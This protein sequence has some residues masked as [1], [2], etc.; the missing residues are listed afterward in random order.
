MKVYKTQDIRNVV[1]LGH[2]GCGKA[3]LAG[4]RAPASG[5]AHRRGRVGPG[6]H[7]DPRRGQLH[8]AG[9]QGLVPQHTGSGDGAL[10]GGPVQGL[11]AGAYTLDQSLSGAQ[12]QE[13]DPAQIPQG[14]NRP[15][16][17]DGLVIPGPLRRARLTGQKFHAVHNLSMEKNKTSL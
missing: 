14:V 9:G 15:V 12:G 10:L 11:P 16:K 3:T 6:E 7:R 13:G 4:S 2:G 1:I 8:P 17:G 5:G